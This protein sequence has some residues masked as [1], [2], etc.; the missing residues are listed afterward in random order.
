MYSTDFKLIEKI[1]ETAP[2]PQGNV[3]KYF[4]MLKNVAHCLEHSET[5][6][7]SASQ[8]AQNYVKHT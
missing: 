2:Q 5:P 3:L 1:N 7:L 6:S 4:A 8:Q